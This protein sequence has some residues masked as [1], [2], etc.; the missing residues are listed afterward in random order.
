MIE[1][2]RKCWGWWLWWLPMWTSTCVVAEANCEVVPSWSCMSKVNPFV[3][4][5]ALVICRCRAQKEGS[6]YKGYC[7]IFVKRAESALTA[8][9]AIGSKTLKIVKI[10]LGKRTCRIWISSLLRDSISLPFFFYVLIFCAGVWHT[11][12][13]EDTQSMAEAVH[14][15]MWYSTVLYNRVQ[16]W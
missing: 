5:I 1:D 8:A 16:N 6:E 9:S 7:K 11:R 13:W 14:A 10:E 15:F 4:I 12:A 3:C 2:D